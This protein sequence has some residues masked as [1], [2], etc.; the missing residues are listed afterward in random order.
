MLQCFFVHANAVVP[1]G[2]DH[3]SLPD[4]SQDKEH[5]LSVQIFDAMI[6]GI[7][8]QWLDHQLDDLPVK[9][10]F[11]YI[12][13][14]FQ[15]IPVAKLLDRQIIT[16]ILDLP[17]YRDDLILIADALAEKLCPAPKSSA[18]LLHFFHSLPSR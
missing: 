17:L 14:I 11:V 13:D 8:H 2:D 7:F 16:G 6:N 5:P 18:P 15:L 12:N 4:L 9:D 1:Y 3:L 10:L